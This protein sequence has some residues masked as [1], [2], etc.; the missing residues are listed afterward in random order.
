MRLPSKITSFQESSIF[1]MI[2][3]LNILDE[4]KRSPI[5]VFKKCKKNF[6]SLNEF[7]ETLDLLFGLG[8]VELDKLS[9]DLILC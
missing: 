2:T 7:I 4:E 3:I 5:E 9:G 6:T 1:K 8:K